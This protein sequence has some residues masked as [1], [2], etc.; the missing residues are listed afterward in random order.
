MISIG[1]VTANVTL[2]QNPCPREA[3]ILRAA[4]NCIVRNTLQKAP[5]IDLALVSGAERDSIG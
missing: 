3:A 5:D 4:Q 1:T 2:P